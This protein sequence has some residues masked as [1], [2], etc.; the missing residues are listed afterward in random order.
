M[1]NT[2]H[3]RKN[4]LAG[5]IAALTAL[6]P[7]AGFASTTQ[8]LWP[9]GGMPD[10]QAGVAA[11]YLEWSDAPATNTGS[12]VIILPGADYANP[13][14]GAAL[15][16]LEE[17][18][19]SNGVACVWLRHRPSASGLSAHQTAWEDGQRAV[20]LVRQAAE[21]R[22]YGADKIGVLGFADGAHL[23]LLLATSSQTPAYARVDAVDDIAC[24]VNF[25]IPM[26]PT[27]VLSDGMTVDPVFA[28]DAKT[29]TT[30][31]F[32][33]ENDATADPIGSTRLYR[34]FRVKKVAAELHLRP[35]ADHA[36]ADA[37]TFGRAIEFLCQS[38]FLGELGA[39]VAAFDRWASDEDR[40]TYIKENI[41]PD[42]QT[43]D[44]QDGQVVPFIEWHLPKE[45]KTRAI[46]II[47]AGGAYGF[48]NHDGFEVVPTR[49]YLNEKG[50][51]V[52]ALKYRTPRPANLPKHLS[53]WQDLQRAIRLVRAEA[54]ARGL[55]PDSIGIMGG[56][57]AGHLTLMGATT[58]LTPAYDRI[59]EIDDQPCGVKWAVAFYPAYAL[60]DGADGTNANGGNTDDD[61]LVDDFAFDA[62]TCGMFFI[63]GDADSYAA[64]NSVKCWEKLRAMGLDG[65]LHT[66][67]TRGHTFQQNASPGTASYNYNDIVWGYVD[68]FAAASVGPRIVDGEPS[69]DQSGITDAKMIQDLIDAAAAESPAGTVTLAAGT[70]YV[71]AQLNVTNGVTLAGQ[72]WTNT[73]I[74][75]VVNES[76]WTAQRCAMLDGG[77]RLEGVALT[78][79]AIKA[80]SENGAGA[81]VK[82]GT[83]SWCCITNN[84]SKNH[85]NSGYGV[86]FAGGQGSI[87]H[88]IV[89]NNASASGLQGGFGAGIAVNDTTGAVTIDTC[90]VAGNAITTGGGSGG[91]LCV[92]NLE[93]DCTVR[94]CTIAGN[95]A[96]S[97]SGGLDLA[98]ATGPGKLVLVNTILV[99]NKVNGADGN[100]RHNNSFFDATGSKNCFVGL[101][102]E[103]AVN[104]GG[105][106]HDLAGFLS[107]DPGFAGAANGDYHLAAGSPAIGAGATVAGIGVDLDA[108]AFG[109]TPS[110][111]CYEAGGAEPP[112]PHV[113][114]WGSATYTWTMTPTGYDC[115]ATAVCT[116]DSSHVT[117]ETVTAAYEVVREPT[118]TEAG[119]GLYTATFANAP[120]AGTQTKTV[121]LPKTGSDPT[122]AVAPSGDATGATD[123]LTIQDLI[124]AAAPT[125]GTVTLGSGVFYIDAQ[126]NVTGGVTLVGQGW[127]NTVI[128][129]VVNASAWTAQRCA[130]LDDGAKL[131]GVVLTGGAI[132]AQSENGAGAW[133]RNG[134]ISRCCIT[135]NVGGNHNVYGC[136]VSFSGGQGTI[137]HSIIA[138][139]GQTGG[140][141]FYGGGIGALD[142]VGPVTVDTCLIVRN[143]L[144][145]GAGGGIGI[146]NL[147]GDCVVRNCTV[148]GNTANTHAAGIRLEN[149][150]SGNSTA[151]GVV[152]NTIAV[153][154]M[155]SGA[156]ANYADNYVVDKTESGNCLFGLADEAALFANSLSGDPA[157]ADAG[158]GDYHLQATSAAI[159]AGAAY[160]GIGTDLD[161]N[162]FAATPS[163]GCYEAGGEPPDQPTAPV[164][165]TVTATPGTTTA[166]I[167]GAIESVGNNGA[168][169]CDVYLALDGGA[170]TKI[171][172]GATT[173]FLYE[174]QG[175]DALTAYGYSISISNNAA[176]PLGATASG[177][178]RTKAAPVQ[179]GQAI[180]PGA[181]SERTRWTIQDAIDAAAILPEPGTVTLG[182]GLFE[183]DAQL[184]VTGGVTLVGQGWEKTVLKQVAATPTA[185]TRVVWIDGGATVG[186]LAITGGHVVRPGG[187]SWGAGAFVA[188]G[189]ITWCCISNNTS[190]AANSANN[191]GGGVGFGDG[192]GRIDHSIVADNSVVGLQTSFGGG[193]AIRHPTGPVTVDACL[194]AGNVASNAQL[195][196][197]ALTYGGA[198]GIVVELWAQS[199]NYP[200]TVRNTTIAGNSAEGAAPRSVAGAVYTMADTGSKFAMLDCIV[201]GNTTT[202][203]NA[204]VE[205]SYDG[206][207]DYCLFDVEEDK[208]GE[209]SLV[210]SPAFVDAAN[211]DYRLALDSPAVGAGETYAGIG[212]DL[213]DAAFSDPPS[214]GC[215]EYGELAAKPAFDV[216][217]GASFHP[218]TNVAL[219]CA[220]SGAKIYY[221]TD[222]SRPTDRSTEYTGPIGLS[223]TTTIKARAYAADLGPS[224]VAT[225]TYTYREPVD[226]G[227]IVPVEGDPAATR[228]TIQ[229]A[230]DA[231]APTHGTVVLAGG[232][233][234]IDA[235]LNVT[236]GVTLVGQGWENTVIRAADGSAIRL[237]MID[238][239]ATVAKLTLTGGDANTQSA[240]TGVEVAANTPSY[241]GAG[242][243]VRNG[244]ISWCC[245]SNNVGSTHYMYGCGVSFSDG[246]GTIDHCLVVD[247]RS[248]QVQNVYGAGIGALDTA[249]PVIIDAC[250]VVDNLIA[251]NGAGGGIGIRGANHDCVI[252]NCTV[253]GNA[254]VGNMG[255]SYAGGISLEHMSGFSPGKATIINTIAVENKKS[256]A[257]SNYLITPPLK[258][259]TNSRSCFFG[260]ATEAN[261]ASGSLY[262]D[263][264]FVDAAN[265]DYHLLASSPAKET[266]WSYTYIGKDLDD[267]YFIWDTPSMG[268]YEYDPNAQPRPW[269]IPGPNGGGIQ[270]I[271]DYEG[272]T[273]IVFTS[274]ALTNDTLTVGF[275]AGKVDGD[276]LIV[277]LLC[278]ENLADTEAFRLPAKL[279]NGSLETL[280]V[281]EAVLERPYPHL[282]AVG[283]ATLEE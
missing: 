98:S 109:A 100:L 234:E 79:G 165:G 12:C 223:A 67:A 128:K 202:G 51:A 180:L 263:P 19:L 55:D 15:R 154:N 147:G 198:G 236:G 25:A 239:G 130:M 21:E 95:E 196:T 224:A 156:E 115:T 81:W 74:K 150:A 2:V 251:G 43:P 184:M 37:D 186:H 283:V 106:N 203:T 14:D 49:R 42:G 225:A 82:N 13:G 264:L 149:R 267:K 99:G 242:A 233:F 217:S 185:D 271:D 104:I 34:A 63:H 76:S 5:F 278:K 247:N 262:G 118:E 73:V 160:A 16:P 131:E 138:D 269:D 22:G 88:S 243:W 158:G 84:A 274:I 127:E 101:A 279:T 141:S 123:R 197:G 119:E 207:V 250:L 144:T 94:N 56:S 9:E 182:E 97:N 44:P 178:F 265:G 282:F 232:I 222:G 209:H 252:R 237:A 218:T 230:I 1:P 193:I 124:D 219:T 77:A 111:G 215:Y 281:L 146:K 143:T 78:G 33:S 47:Y 126:L 227:A 245:I 275:R 254:V 190:G 161:G 52:V 256:G 28:F 177:S 248:T 112:P 166:T 257:E 164:L 229:D 137:D 48:N 107:G 27:G 214:M 59:D 53:A 20:R 114:T 120:F 113:H 235:Q 24:N 105:V 201:A 110:I 238:E 162:A 40:A 116:A 142:T 38:K 169:A 69:G 212:N 6:L 36:P 174:I 91:G 30:C 93:G 65:E 71:N 195:G 273:Y 54:P 61:V 50:M 129:R 3:W 60:T 231:A 125:R 170:A 85:S 277:A 159:G 189:T 253:V 45:L 167:A 64:M 194:V 72:G 181:T 266:G 241:G 280:G 70:F 83:I 135:N 96:V 31:L 249:G 272:H 173:S 157:F 205:L 26:S 210:G 57:A 18:L 23:A 75:R 17:K 68:D 179:P 80:M 66:L 211:G 136:G 206:G 152:I 41:W 244:T 191:Y 187:W 221:T 216:A 121:R 62:K 58:S 199:V 102:S 268:C 134:T 276:G 8:T 260:L 86:S 163:I 171:A 87:D 11:P 32:H 39:E 117:N 183:I 132:R 4:N 168:T 261:Q 155:K 172:E 108:K 204:A 270:A 145:S 89:A 246:Q 35:G 200:M 176:A 29:C 208:V 213:G 151:K 92:K 122:D 103:T 10:A 188:D 255:P 175:L 139:N 258:D 7:L 192:R 259:S 133:V 90:L 148:V 220:T 240:A 226:P 140:A 153:G 228:W 46:Q